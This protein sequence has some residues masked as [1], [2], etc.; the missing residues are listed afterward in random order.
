MVPAAVV[1]YY[2]RVRTPAVQRSLRALWNPV[3]GIVK[4]RKANKQFLQKKYSNSPRYYYNT[5]PCYCCN[6]PASCFYFDLHTTP[7]ITS[8][9][10]HHHGVLLP[11][12]DHHGMD[13]PR[14]GFDYRDDDVFCPLSRF[15]T[16]HRPWTFGDTQPHPLG[17]YVWYVIVSY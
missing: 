8:Q 2:E 10:N 13:L 15:A 14:A 7:S 16:R 6:L 5:I 12:S 1:D 3:L 11:L 4:K 9:R 17:V